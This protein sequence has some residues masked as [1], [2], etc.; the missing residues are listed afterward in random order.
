MALL[1]CLIYLLVLLVVGAAI[2]FV[3]VGVERRRLSEI[4]A[5][6]LSLGPGMTAA[7]LLWL[8]LC[9]LAP[10]RVLII[11]IG[12][13]AIA[14]LIAVWKLQRFA[15]PVPPIPSRPWWLNLIALP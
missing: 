5:L 12:G 2:A 15:I 3:I 6:M 7:I 1:W 13:G 4:L 11:L 8:S 10:G 9:G 14:S